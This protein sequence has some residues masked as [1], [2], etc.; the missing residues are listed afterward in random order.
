VRNSLKLL[1][2]I[3]I[4]STSIDGQDRVAGN[5][6]GLDKALKA[7]FESLSSKRYTD[8]RTRFEEALLIISKNPT[9]SFWLF[10]KITLPDED[11]ADP[12][13]DQTAQGIE[14]FRHSMG[15]RQALLMFVTFSYQL[16]GNRIQ[17]EKY[18]D[19]VYDIQGPL[20]GL[21]WRTFTPPLCALFQNSV[22]ND[23]SENYGRYLFMNGRLMLSSGQNEAGLRIMEEARRLAP[24]DPDLPARLAELYVINGDA[25]NARKYAQLSLDINP[26]QNRVLIDY[27]T[28]DW[29]AGE[30]DAAV[31]HAG[32]AIAI[33]AEMPGPHATLSFVALERGDVAT[34]TREA[35]IGDKL[36]KG[37]PFYRTVLAACLV[38]GGKTAAAK[39]LLADSWKEG[40]P[41]EAQLRSWFFRGKPLANVLKL[42]DSK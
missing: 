3:L 2:F 36:S 38:A 12:P 18:F 14:S 33:D 26:K 34:A 20:W 39:K 29:L 9:P 41:D 21:S 5:D 15:T 23:G 7:G 27:A 19:A 13:R 28:A 17:A 16:E 8:A 30:L 1:L 40:P 37:H 35:E 4:V 10:T 31:K 24:K 32:E 6:G 42:L 25:A 22:T 11:P